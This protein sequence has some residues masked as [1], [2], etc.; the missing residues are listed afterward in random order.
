L[1][2]LYILLRDM[3]AMQRSMSRDIPMMMIFVCTFF[4]RKG[5]FQLMQIY[6]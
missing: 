3:C 5:M 6:L 4:T 2:E 1:R